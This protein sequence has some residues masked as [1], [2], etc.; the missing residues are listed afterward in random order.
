MNKY[1]LIKNNHFF[2]ATL[3]DKMTH[4]PLNW[5]IEKISHHITFNR[6][7]TPTKEL[8]N[9]SG[10]LP[11]ITISDMKV[12]NITSY[13]AKIKKNKNTKVFP[14]GTLLG[15]FK[16]SVGKFGF[17]TQECSTNEAIMGFN[18]DCNRHNSQF[19]YYIFPDFFIKNAIPNQQGVLLLNSEI[20]GNIDFPVPPLSQQNAIAE[21]LSEQESIIQ[22]IELLIEKYGQRFQYLSNELLSGRLRVK[23]LDGKLTLYKNP[24]DNWKEVEANGDTI[25]IPSDWVVEKLINLGDLFAGK[26]KK[27]E[28]TQEELK[29]ND[30]YF[31]VGGEHIGEKYFNLSNKIF[32]SK[33]LFNKSIKS[34]I[35]EKDILIIKDGATT[36]KNMFV[37]NKPI[38]HMLLNEHV[39][40]FVAKKINHFYLYL[41]FNGMVVQN[42]L[43]EK[44][45]GIIPS[46][47][48][49]NFSQIQTIMTK[50]ITEQNLIA[51]LMLLQEEL[52]QQQQQLL[53]KEKQKFEW[54]M[55]NLLTGKYLIEEQNG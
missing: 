44:I 43:I 23:E 36:G 30:T 48:Q 20:I 6:G 2:E 24:D 21:I 55:D 41:L 4:I 47:N 29:I 17:T 33:E 27:Y 49:E 9:Y 34:Q 32:V 13:T 38:K 16:M 35:L 10:N 28:P 3:N 19:L 39:Y 11:W 54:L 8:D 46:L 25:E 37:K 12:K 22:N 50:N 14:N 5:H 7:G 15:S 42:A 18:I 26:R 40:R 51:D 52:I 31:S 53:S 1:K 45:T